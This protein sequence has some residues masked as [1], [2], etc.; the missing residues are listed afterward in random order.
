MDTPKASPPAW[1]RKIKPAVTQN[2]STI[3]RFFRKREYK[4]DTSRYASRIDRKTV[5]TLLANKRHPAS[6]RT[7]R[8][9][10]VKMETEPEGNGLFCFLG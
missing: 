3:G 10:A 1:R 2:R 9:I 7:Q 5:E 6:M 4:A 8:I